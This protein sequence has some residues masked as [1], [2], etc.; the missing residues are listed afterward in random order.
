M[1]RPQ[2][3][4]L[5]AE[6]PA[7]ER[8]P[9]PRS[10]TTLSRPR[11]LAPMSLD[12]MRDAV[13]AIRRGAFARPPLQHPAPSKATA[14]STL[15]PPWGNATD[16]GRVVLVLPGHAG[17]GASTVAVALAE[18]LARGQTVQLLDYATPLRS[19]LAS[20]SSI[21][22]GT[23]GPWRHG[24]RGSVDVFRLMQPTPG[25]EDPGLPQGQGRER[26]LVV[27]TDAASST[28]WLTSSEEL[29]E[30]VEYVVVV[31]RLTVPGVSQAEQVLDA[32][33]GLV[34][35]AALGP[36]QWPRIV[37]ASC[38]PRLRELRARGRV[39][40]VPID[41]K[42]ATTGLTGD[43]LPKA[44]AAAGRSLATLVA[45]QSPSAHRHRRQAVLSQ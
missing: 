36:S 15:V 22:L 12:E 37:E 23:A 41:R 43:S 17:A 3:T 11:A 30:H 13:A 19:G 10:T 5:G 21:E 16:C 25:S 34:L 24:R 35:V 1:S 2:M 7:P 14:F 45:P 6:S 18:G 33:G 8:R 4:P 42:L 38:G 9:Q 20:V 27:D 31:T 32:V 40:R 44:V 28:T 39:V 29:R 26:W